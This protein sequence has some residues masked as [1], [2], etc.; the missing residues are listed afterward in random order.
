L[1]CGLIGGPGRTA[2]AAAPPEARSAAAMAISEVSAPLAAARA[3]VRSPQQAV[4]AGIAAARNQGVTS[5]A[6]VINRSTGRLVAS[7]GGDQ[8]TASASIVKLFTAA[9][10]LVRNGAAGPVAAEMRYMIRY[11]DDATET[12][13]WNCMIV[14]WARSRYHLSSRTGNSAYSCLGWWGT[15][16]ITANDMV[17]FL[18]RA[19]ADSAVW[20]VLSAAMLSA[21][22]SGSDGFDQ[23]FGFNRLIGSGS[24]QGWTNIVRGPFDGSLLGLHS[25]GF[26]NRYIGAVLQTGHSYPVMRSTV[27]TT[28]ALIANSA[29][30][31]TGEPPR[32]GLPAAAS[33]SFVRG[34]YR[35]LLGRTDGAGSPSVNALINDT[36]TKNAVALLVST[37]LERRHRLV[38]AAYAGCLVRSADSGGLAARSSALFSGTLSDLYAA[39][40]GS[41]EA[42]ARVHGDLRRWAAQSIR[43]VFGRTATAAEITTYANRAHSTGL[44]ATVRTMMVNGAATRYQ[45]NTVYRAMLGRPAD[46]SAV[47]RYARIMPGRGIFSVPV[48]LALSGEFRSHWA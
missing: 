4:D 25:V 27:T 18:Y 13:Y 29:T 39:L 48:E 11:S 15:V 43:A 47:G 28:A 36:T 45:L 17:R 46:A 2:A 24:K 20:P 1:D 40:C 42:S 8:P 3:P 5:Y 10:Y 19:S 9:Y 26:T 12:K 16:D 33:A 23:N 32:P 22:N 6:A 21:A 7:R 38:R 14:D 34:L 35:S 44:A 30:V 41:A 31:L 37:S